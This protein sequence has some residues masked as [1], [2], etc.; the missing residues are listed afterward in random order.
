M[1]KQENAAKVLGILEEAWKA[2]AA[3]FLTDDYLYV[4][5]NK[6][7]G[8]WQETSFV[9]A[10]GSLQIRELESEKALMFLIEEITT[11]LAGS[12]DSGKDYVIAFNPASQAKVTERIKSLA[13]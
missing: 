7:P 12:L 13:G 4:L 1:S 3:T 11:G 2:K 5:I 8:K 9:F 10:D 6:G